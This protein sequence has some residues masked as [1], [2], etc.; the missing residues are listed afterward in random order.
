M[1]TQPPVRFALG[2][3]QGHPGKITRY[4]WVQ[5]IYPSGRS[6]LSNL[7]TIDRTGSLTSNNQ[8]TISWQ[9]ADFAIGYDV[10]E[11]P[12]SSIPAVNSTDNIAVVQGVTSGQIVLSAEPNLANWTYETGNG[13]GGGGTPGGNPGEIQ[14]NIAGAFGSTAN[15]TWTDTDSL[16]AGLPQ[17]VQ[18]A[19]PTGNIYNPGGMS[20]VVGGPSDSQFIASVATSDGYIDIEYDAHFIAQMGDV[21]PVT[22][23]AATPGIAYEFF[24]NSIEINDTTSNTSQLYSLIFYN[25]AH[26]GGKKD[27]AING[28]GDVAMGFVSAGSG[29]PIA[30]SN[31]NLFIKGNGSLSRF[32]GSIS[33]LRNTAPADG[34]IAAN[35]LALW[36]D[37]TNGASKLMIKAKQADGT[38]K[39]ASVA[40]T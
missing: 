8:I 10:I 4:F 34:D 27:F 7:V 19:G 40:L 6:I 9:P 38:V 29:D 24:T 12:T 15:L 25:A 32:K 36:F 35:E 20:L 26:V 11:T 39:T 13:G 14:I 2:T 22:G 28:A 21:I 23:A 16:R 17:S 3:Y 37:P 18:L 30:I 5:A 33:T 1:I 31:A